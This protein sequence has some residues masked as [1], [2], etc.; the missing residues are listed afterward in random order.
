[1]ECSCSKCEAQN[2]WYREQI[3]DIEMRA[4]QEEDRLKARV[5]EID[6]IAKQ[7]KDQ[8][9]ARI[10]EL[11][12]LANQ[13][14]YQLPARMR[15][16]DALANE[17]KH[18]VQARIHAN[19][20]KFSQELINWDAAWRLHSICPLGIIPQKM[21]KRKHGDDI[22]H[23]GHAMVL[24]SHLSEQ[25]FGCSQVQVSLEEQQ[26]QQQFQ[27]PVIQELSQYK[28][29]MVEEVR[30]LSRCGQEWQA[31]LSHKYQEQE[32]AQVDQQLQQELPQE[33]QLQQENDN[34]EEEYDDDDD[35]DNNDDDDDDDIDNIDDDYEE[36]NQRLLQLL[37][38]QISLPPI[39]PLFDDYPY[40]SYPMTDYSFLFSSLTMGGI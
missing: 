13:E 21:L 23:A 39:M 17:E 9:E 29:L 33:Q 7:E 19:S 18:K 14:K 4:K 12:A 34:E 10:H 36:Q 6:A 5:L 11:D 1:M 37:M 8:M 32:V 35:D 20:A 31:S 22:E 3:Q 30:R 2:E 38:S 40:Y 28:K 26:L 24:T 15:V 25:P 16:I 27:Q